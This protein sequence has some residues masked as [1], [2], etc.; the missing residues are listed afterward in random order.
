MNL[1]NMT[2]FTVSIKRVSA[3]LFCVFMLTGF[4]Q[5]SATGAYKDDS[6]LVNAKNFMELKGQ[7]KFLKGTQ[8]ET[9]AL[10]SAVITV[11]NEANVPVAAYYSDKKG[12][13]AMKLPLNRR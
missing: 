8:N 1:F 10:D 2:Y 3:M 5:A 13:T 6:L 4:L 12:K 7:I 9:G 11:Y